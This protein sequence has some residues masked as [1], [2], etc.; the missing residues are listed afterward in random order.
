MYGHK[1]T[2][3]QGEEPNDT[4]LRGLS[5]VTGK[6]LGAGLVTCRDSGEGWPPTLPEFRAACLGDNGL[7]AADKSAHRIYK[8]ELLIESTTS[9]DRRSRLAEIMGLL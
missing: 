1:W 8:P 6:Q 7:I 2:S 5:D 3:Q 4:W 9:T